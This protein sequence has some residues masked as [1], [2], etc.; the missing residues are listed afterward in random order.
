MKIFDKVKNSLV[1]KLPFV[2]YKTPNSKFLQG[3]FQGNDS[4]NFVEDFSDSKGFVFA[5]FNR[6]Q[7]SVLFPEEDSCLEKE[8]ID[9]DVD[10]SDN[11]IFINDSQRDFHIQLVEKGVDAIER[12][13]FRKVVLSRKEKVVLS[14]DLNQLEVFSRLLMKYPSAFVYFWYHPKVGKWMGATPETLL[15][16][17][18]KLFKTM[19]LAGT[20]VY[21]KELA[22]NWS[23]KEIE[24][25]YIVTD[26]IKGKLQPICGELSVGELETVRIGNLL[27]LR[28]LITGKIDGDIGRLIKELHPTPAVCGLPKKITK[29]FIINEEGYDREFYTGFL[30]ELNREK[31]GKTIS[32][33]FVNLRCMKINSERDIN[34]YVGGGITLDSEPMKEWLETVAKSGAMKSVL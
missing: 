27:H 21:Q 32:K 12:N 15:S 19:S 8:S 14:S 25:Q 5:P 1:N 2:V 6:N 20:Q 30:G 3:F 31:H 16:V 26:Y 29:K 11:E 18:G 28:T 9:V 24:E 33:L 34:I 17:E 23:S 4:L 10:F 22:P 13:V 7:S